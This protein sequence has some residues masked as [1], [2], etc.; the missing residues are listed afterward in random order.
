M[1][2]YEMVYIVQPQLAQTKIEQLN[3]R[4]RDIIEGCEGKL[5]YAKSLGKRSLAYRIKKQTKG[6]YYSLCYAA[7][8]DCTADMEHVLRLDENVLRF[9]TVLKS[10][11]VDISAREKEIAVRGEA[12]SVT[13]DHTLENEAMEEA[14][15]LANEG[16]PQESEQEKSG[17]EGIK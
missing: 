1:R 3:G 4:L 7:Q 14:V 2:E 10:D 5:F 15:K 6:I 9:L 12:E 8:G 16:L 13:I 11:K 17:E